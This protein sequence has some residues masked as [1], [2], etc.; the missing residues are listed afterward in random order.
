MYGSHTWEVQRQKGTRSYQHH[1]E[2]RN[3]Q[4]G[5]RG[6]EWDAGQEEQVFGDENLLSAQMGHQTE[7]ISVSNF[8]FGKDPK[9]RFSWVVREGQRFLLCPQGHDC[10]KFRTVHMPQCHPL[11]H[12]PLAATQTHWCHY[13]AWLCFLAHAVIKLTAIPSC[14]CRTQGELS[15]TQVLAQGQKRQ[16]LPRLPAEPPERALGELQDVGTC[17]DAGGSG[18]FSLTH[19]S[20]KCLWQNMVLENCGHRPTGCLLSSWAAQQGPVEMAV[21]VA[22]AFRVTPVQLLA[23]ALCRCSDPKGNACP[24]WLRLLTLP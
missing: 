8:Y 20:W 13:K 21:G 16:L 6:R 5:C 15:A 4:W 9:F 24:L 7:F 18:T 14:L 17:T 11:G 23:G 1:P 22:P 12:L 3:G 10:L 2:P 19:S